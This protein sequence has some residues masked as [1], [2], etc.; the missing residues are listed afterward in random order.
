M[1]Q[2]LALLPL[3]VFFFTCCGHQ[4]T[5]S[6]PGAH[7]RRISGTVSTSDGRPAPRAIVIITSLPN[8]DEIAFARTDPLGKFVLETSEVNVSL[9]V[10]TG[11]GWA[12]VPDVKA[13]NENLSIQ[14]SNQCSQLRGQ[15]DLDDPLPVSI[16]VLRIGGFEAQVLG[17]FG[18]QV[19]AD[20]SFEVCLPPGEY[21]INL[22]SGFTQRTILTMVPSVGR[23]RVHAATQKYATTPPA[24]PLEISGELQSTAIA[25]LQRSVRILGLGESNHGTAEYTD[26]RVELSIALARQYEFLVVMIEAGYGEVLPLDDYIRGANIAVVDAIEGLGVWM[27]R[28][29]SFLAAVEKLKAYNATVSASD[30]IRIM[31]IDVQRTKGAVAELIRYQNQLS[32]LE[33]NALQQLEEERGKK[34]L[35]FAPE[36][37][38]A[39]RQRLELLAAARD[40]NG[41][42]SP[43]NRAALAARS[44]LLRLELLEQHGFWNQER[45]RD[46]GMAQMAREALALDPRLR[47]TLWAHVG[48]L[49]RE[50][51]VGAPTMGQHLA[52]WL[53]DGYKVWA[54]LGLEGAIR[55]RSPKHKGEVIDHILPMPP[56]YTLEAVLSRAGG[57]KLDISYWDLR[58]QRARGSGWLRGLRWLRGIG[59]VFPDHREPLGLYDLT[60]LDGVVLFRHVS[61]TVPLVKS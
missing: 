9:A 35:S 57:Y 31:G 6:N 52:A 39:M 44:I 55:A 25:K 42:G 22:P 19:A 45:A 26:E 14:L 28:T 27:W 24:F 51:V 54:L 2:V 58:H 12:F 23:L 60:S 59:A 30:Q 40:G 43:A 29:K 53:G 34:W 33:L 37:K 18:V 47:A 32:T 38:A 20:Y 17:L 41:P 48:H 21:Y 4:V 15:V 49:A 5:S 8:I 61:P 7:L 46:K 13:G 50:F 3:S 36:V 16:D 10:A 11:G 56:V 1:S